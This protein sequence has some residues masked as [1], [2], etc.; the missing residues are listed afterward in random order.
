[1][2]G[3]KQLEIYLQNLGSTGKGNNSLE[4]YPT[5]ASAAS[6]ILNLAYEDGNIRGK[7]VLDL[8]CGNGIFSCGAAALGALSVTGFDIDPDQIEAAR[9]NCGSEKVTFHAESVE[10]V[11]G[12]YDTVI[13]NPPF[14]SVVAHADLPFLEKAIATGNF[15]YSLHNAKSAD[16]V[17][18]F[19]RTNGTIF[20]KESIGLRIGRI[21]GHHKKDQ[22]IIEA[23]LFCV[24]TKSED[25]ASRNNN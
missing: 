13:M 20:R 16:F 2:K 17:A 23:V 21:Y 10:L 3:K 24:R 15:I 5:D 9:K 18:S 12:E 19:Y 7:R 25:R 6:Y 8:G 22:M 11:H 14:G 4:Q 1:M